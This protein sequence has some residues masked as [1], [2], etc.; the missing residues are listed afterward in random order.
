MKTFI[1]FVLLALLF[2]TVFSQELLKGFV[3][4]K[5]EKGNE[6]PLAGVNSYWLG[7]STGTITDTN[8]MFT[9]PFVEGSK[10][11]VVRCVGYR[12]DTIAIKTQH[13]IR[14]FLKSE[15]HDIGDVN[16]VGE[17]QASFLDYANPFNKTI[18][19]EK[20]LFK[21]AC[22]N[23][24]ESFQ[25]NPS[26]DVS[27][28]DAITGTKQIE[29]LGLSG[30][31]TQTTME[32]MPYIRG[33]T[34]NVGLTFIP[35]SWIEAI[36]VSKGLGSVANG[37][38]SITGQ[39]DVDLRKPEKENEKQ[40]FLNLYGN[41]DRR[42]EA[43]L[44]VRERLSDRISSMT[45]LHISSQ[46][47]SVD[48]NGDGFRDM[49]LFTTF[50]VL[51]RWNFTNLN[52]ITG[53]L[54]VQYV[55][56]KKDGGTLNQSSTAAY[57]YGTQSDLFRVHG[58]TG[59]VFSKDHN[60]SIGI[61]WSLSRYRSSSHF[62]LR[63]YNGD[64]QSGY[65]NV[66]YQSS[67]AGT[68]HNF[69]TGISFLF[70]GFD[71]T[72]D[73]TP[74]RRVERVPGVFFEYTLSPSEKLSVVAGI[75]ADEH[76]AYGTMITPRLH[77]RYT[78]QEDW[79]LRLAAGRGYRTANIFAENSTVFASSRKDSIVSTVKFGYG[80]KQEI[81]WN[82]G[83]NL[84]HYFQFNYH[85]ATLMI[86]LYRTDFEQLVLADLDSNPHQVRFYS[87][88]NG[89]YSNS[90]QTELDIQPLERLDVRVAYRYLDV[91][92]KLN[93]MWL[94][95]PLAAQHRV[96]MTVSY[97]TDRDQPDDPQTSFDVTM[98][99]FGKKR[100]PETLLNPDSLRARAYSP[101]FLTVNLQATRTFIKGL[102]V[103]L[104]IENL[105]NFKQSDPILDAANPQGQFFDASLIWGPLSGRMMYA[106]LRLRI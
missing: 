27:F 86:D 74:Y 80:L 55:S 43:N 101:G 60:Q 25:T 78:P 100:I 99:W 87:V 95:R 46:Q 58:K 89:S 71:E 5:D 19:T 45:L 98:Q 7:T 69:R 59:F 82:Y 63:D 90:V 8:G 103:Y 11:L 76:N 102:D 49:P 9:L 65:I 20:E 3:G 35:G 72:F 68:L 48:E 79:V 12:P 94:E 73:H 54:G 106:G 33:L 92:Q 23:L 66:L 56:D 67:L 83:F 96:L 21:A 31:Y 105:F 77:I 81:A 88:P 91:K 44:N 37:Y 2:S 53:Q 70:D 30:I 41:Q 50:N 10:T 39:I 32:N 34:S 97:A 6:H 64:E 24:S 52:G 22:C 61:Q 57:L 15:A 42:M 26:V 84:T 93:G 18:V 104:G 16:I 62:G 75:R 4:E 14:L 28:T 51:Q 40:F 13:T 29:M 85:D 47:N 17:R 36:N 38:E 1:L